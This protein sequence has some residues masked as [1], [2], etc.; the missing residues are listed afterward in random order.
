MF[1]GA[2]TCVHTYLPQE[3]EQELQPIKELE[4]QYRAL[5]LCADSHGRLA[6]LNAELAWSELRKKEMVG[7][8]LCMCLCVC[9]LRVGERQHGQRK[10]GWGWGKGKHKYIRTYARMCLYSVSSGTCLSYCLSYPPL[11]VIISH[12]YVYLGLPPETYI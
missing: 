6:L 2:C 5:Q 1:V 8:T 3:I 12:K 7:N 9:V 11:A 4:D 10:E